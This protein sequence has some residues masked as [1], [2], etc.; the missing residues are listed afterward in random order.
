MCKKFAVIWAQRSPFLVGLT[1]ST[2]KK[3]PSATEELGINIPAISKTLS[4][5]NLKV[6]YWTGS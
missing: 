2:S 6:K 1:L 5:Y 4:E 3:I